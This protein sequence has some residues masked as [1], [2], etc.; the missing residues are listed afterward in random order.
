MMLKE[1]TKNR[2]RLRLVF[3]VPLLMGMLYVF[4]Q[5]ESEN[6]TIRTPAG[7]EHDGSNP[8]Q[9]TYS[10]RRNFE[11]ELEMYEEWKY[12]KNFVR[13]DKQY[14][15][16]HLF[17]NAVDA[18]LFN[19]EIIPF[20]SLGKKVDEVVRA[21]RKEAL[22]INGTD[23]AVIITLC[24]DRETTATFLDRVLN[25]LEEV[26]NDIRREEL[27]GKQGVLEAGPDKVYPLLVYFADQLLYFVDHR[28]IP[29]QDEVNTDVVVCIW[30]KGTESEIREIKNYTLEELKTEINKAFDKSTFTDDM[31]V[32]L[33]W[34]KK[35]INVG[36]IDDVRKTISSAFKERRKTK[37]FM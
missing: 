28:N 8:F 33:Y 11:R 9:K 37:P 5:Q 15:D 16:L 23:K 27:G 35:D 17:I 14:D 7:Q 30:Y 6:A 25:T 10:V 13:S 26:R 22:E 31:F 34:T 36:Q 32:N 2:A 24:Y 20:E 12:G 1:K 21:R 3:F 18:L 4:A 29:K 19:E